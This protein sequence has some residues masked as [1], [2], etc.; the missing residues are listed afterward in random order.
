MLTDLARDTPCKRCGKTPRQKQMPC[1]DFSM[2]CR[3]CGG[4][5]CCEHIM[6]LRGDKVDMGICEECH[7]NAADGTKWTSVHATEHCFIA[8]AAI[9][10]SGCGSCDVQLSGLRALRDSW[11]SGFSCGRAVIRFYCRVGPALA[12]ALRERPRLSSLFVAAFVRPMASLAS[13]HRFCTLRRS[14]A[15]AVGGAM[16]AAAALCFVLIG[17]RRGR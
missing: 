6:R 3:S 12:S 15:V 16:L 9:A 13:G 1:N 7:G 10:A 8:S 4:V 2:R 11:L 17:R 14:A 5:F